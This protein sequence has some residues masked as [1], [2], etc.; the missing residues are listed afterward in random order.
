MR[1]FMNK[2]VVSWKWYIFNAKMLP[3]PSTYYSFCE[4]YVSWYI[5]YVQWQLRRCHEQHYVSWK[6]IILSLTNAILF[7]DSAIRCMQ[8]CYILHDLCYMFRQKC[9]CRDRRTLSG[10]VGK[11]N[12]NYEKVMRKKENH[13]KKLWESYENRDKYVFFSNAI[14]TKLF[15]MSV[16]IKSAQRPRGQVTE[17]YKKQWIFI[18]Q[19]SLEEGKFRAHGH[20]QKAYFWATSNELL[21]FILS[22]DSCNCKTHSNYSCFA[23]RLI[24][25]VA[26]NTVIII[27]VSLCR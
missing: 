20:P 9:Y 11:P 5:L 24:L 8:K 2:L 21:A 12:R 26:K 18:K 3:F 1:I 7:R 4:K 22:E 6:Y 14:K 23:I 15:A 19:G 25:Q 27:L 10:D 13:L 17:S 16:F